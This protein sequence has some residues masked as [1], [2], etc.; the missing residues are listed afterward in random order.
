MNSNTSQSTA[1]AYKPSQMATYTKDPTSMA[2]H[3]DMVNT[4]GQLISNI[5]EISNKD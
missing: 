3:Q 5:K 1:K 4:H 2:N